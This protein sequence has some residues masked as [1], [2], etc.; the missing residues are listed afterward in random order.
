MIGFIVIIIISFIF[1]TCYV[2]ERSLMSGRE[3]EASTSS[4][5]DRLNLPQMESRGSSL[6]RS[7]RS[8]S[9]TKGR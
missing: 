6:D 4:V 5:C 3:R 9:G 7:L 8:T 2:N 1:V